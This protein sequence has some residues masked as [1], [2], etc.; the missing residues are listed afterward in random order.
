VV[1]DEGNR[2]VTIIDVAIPFENRRLALTEKREEKI[3]K[4]GCVAQE[5]RAQGYQVTLDAFIVGAL[6]SWDPANE[7][8][9][10][11]LKIAPRYSS[12]MRRLMVSDTIRWSRDIYVTHLTGHRQWDEPQRNRI[13]DETPQRQLAG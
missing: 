3:N 6:G 1:V 11:H 8:V 7:R 4:Y 2:R 10:K 13:M 9:L 12:L 5:L